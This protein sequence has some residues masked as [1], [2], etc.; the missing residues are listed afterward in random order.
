MTRT[1]GGVAATAEAAATTTVARQTETTSRT[2]ILD[3]GNGNR[4]LLGTRERRNR[5]RTRDECLEVPA[6]RDADELVL[7]RGVVD[8]LDQGFDTARV[9][10]GAGVG[11]QLDDRLLDGDRFA[12]GPRSRHRLEGV[13]DGDDPRLDR[14]RRA[15]QPGR[16]AASVHS[17]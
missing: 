17:L 12:V 9:E 4:S 16:V 5:L 6:V 3:R 15:A 10:L 1:V 7:V 13:G 2:R 8:D 14:D 11:L